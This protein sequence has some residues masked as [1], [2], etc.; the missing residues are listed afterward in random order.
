MTFGTNTPLHTHTADI[1]A[2][3]TG[4]S[5]GLPPLLAIYHLMEYI[6]SI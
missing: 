5:T 6:F 3:E 4:F 1:P 2:D